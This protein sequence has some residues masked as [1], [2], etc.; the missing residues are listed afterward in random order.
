MTRW[1]ADPEGPHEV[2]VSLDSS[3]FFDRYF[4]VF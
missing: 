3:A 4:S 2:A 1:V